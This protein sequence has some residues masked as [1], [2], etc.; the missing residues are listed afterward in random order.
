ME[1][2]EEKAQQFHMQEKLDWEVA[3]ADRQQR[4]LSEEC[5]ALRAGKVLVKTDSNSSN[6][7]TR[8]SATVSY[9]GE[10]RLGVAAARS[11]QRFLSEE[12]EALRAGKVLV[13]QIPIPAIC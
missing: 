2:A 4:F 1:T 11:Q 7:L 8:E 12:C 6:L 9:A 5:E 3:A 13:K 10:A